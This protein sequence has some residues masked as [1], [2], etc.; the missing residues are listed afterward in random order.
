MISFSPLTASELRSDLCSR[1]VAPDMC[2]RAAASASTA[3]RSSTSFSAAV[4]KCSMAAGGT[5]S[6]NLQQ[7]QHQ[8]IRLGVKL[9][10]QWAKL[11]VSIF[12]PKP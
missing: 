3:P 2:A 1:L 6:R 5:E 8:K 4:R 12:Y 11:N 7:T 10:Y 9:I